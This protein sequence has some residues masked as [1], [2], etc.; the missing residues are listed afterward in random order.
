MSLEVC[1]S[2]RALRALVHL[3]LPGPTAPLFEIQA[4]NPHKFNEKWDF[5]TLIIKFAINSNFT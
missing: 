5:W 3:V 2:L 4:R 1:R